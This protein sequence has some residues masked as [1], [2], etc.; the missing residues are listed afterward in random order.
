MT[1]GNVAKSLNIP[2]N[3]NCLTFL[4]EITKP[5]RKNGSLITVSSV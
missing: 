2:P 5:P 1:A 3:E 4:D